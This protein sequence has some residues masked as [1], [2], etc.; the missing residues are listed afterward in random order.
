MSQQ[1]PLPQNF[2]QSKQDLYMVMRVFPGKR[3]GFFLELGAGDGLWISNTLL[4]ERAFGWTGILIE[5]T[6]V[7]ERLR[8]NRPGCICDNSCIASEYKQVTL[9]EVL[10]SGQ[11][12]IHPAAIDNLLLSYVDHETGPPAPAQSGSRYAV[13]QRSYTK[14][15]VPLQHVLRQHNAPKIID[16]F[17]LDVEGSE[18]EILHAFPFGEYGFRCLTIEAPPEPLDRLLQQNGYRVDR[19]L[20][21]DTVYLGPAYQP[22]TG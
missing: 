8:S 7:F 17:S 16:Y 15:A 19:R 10:D 4:L 14:D 20:G 18:Y 5:P 9:H 21:N 2:S 13:P 3:N 11:S 6:R 22:P 12:R 1:P